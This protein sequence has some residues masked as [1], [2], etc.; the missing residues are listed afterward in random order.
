MKLPYKAEQ[1]FEKE[2]TTKERVTMDL[3]YLPVSRDMGK[4]EM[5][6]NYSAAMLSV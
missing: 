5:L 6:K 3:F 1:A 4:A 2:R